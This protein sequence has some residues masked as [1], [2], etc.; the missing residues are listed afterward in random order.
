MSNF[1]PHVF[2]GNENSYP[3]KLYTVGKLMKNAGEQGYF[4]VSTS[5]WW[6]VVG[7]NA[8]KTVLEHKPRIYRGPQ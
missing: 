7:E 2:F 1:G 8:P 6:R 4:Q 3:H 5:T